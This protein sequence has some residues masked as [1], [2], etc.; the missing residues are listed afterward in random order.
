M[1]QLSTEIQSLNASLQEVQ[2]Q[3]DD[4]KSTKKELIAYGEKKDKQLSDEQDNVIAAEK[5]VASLKDQLQQSSD[6]LE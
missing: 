2:K 4:L 6:T 1:T 5:E 3:K